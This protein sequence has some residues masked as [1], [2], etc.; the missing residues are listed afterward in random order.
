MQDLSLSSQITLYVLLA[1]IGLLALIVWGWQIQVLQGKDMK[2]PTDRPT[3]GT[4][5][6][7]FTAS[8]LPIYFWPAP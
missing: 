1:L 6:R 2:T 3:I 8:R 5:R 4:S 7:S